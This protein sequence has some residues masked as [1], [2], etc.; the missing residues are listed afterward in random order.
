MNEVDLSKLPT[1]FRGVAWNDH[2]EFEMPCVV[3][4]PKKY[5]RFKSEGNTGGIEYAV[6]DI[7]EDIILGSP[8][9]DGGLAH[10]CKWRGW[11]SRFGRRKDAWHVTIQVRW[12]IEDGE[13]AFEQVSRKEKFGGRP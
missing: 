9:D 13:L 11:G 1:E 7:C 2:W 6:E 5:R 3:Y 12:F 8:A 4:W 10:E